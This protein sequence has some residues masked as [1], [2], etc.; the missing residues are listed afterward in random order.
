MTQCKWFLF[1]LTATGMWIGGMVSPENHVHQVLPYH[2]VSFAGTLPSISCFCF[3]SI[4]PPRNSPKKCCL[5][6]HPA[7]KAG[8][9]ADGARPERKG[10]ANELKPSSSPWKPSQ[11]GWLRATWSLLGRAKWCV[12]VI[13]MVALPFTGQVRLKGLTFQKI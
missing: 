8:G 5:S 13:R 2:G 6:C 4:R 12:W 9:M 7:A 11:P 1:L 3:S 10:C